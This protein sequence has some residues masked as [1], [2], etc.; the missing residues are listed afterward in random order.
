MQRNNYLLKK[1]C[2][3]I[4]VLMMKGL[5]PHERVQ[6]KYGESRDRETDDEVDNDE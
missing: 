5:I 3:Q 4:T 1:R 2:M 6:Y